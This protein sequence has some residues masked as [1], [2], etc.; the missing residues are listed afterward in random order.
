SLLF[1]LKNFTIQISLDNFTYNKIVNKKIFLLFYI[2]T[3]ALLLKYA[4]ISLV[5][6]EING[7]TV[8][9]DE[10]LDLIFGGSSFVKLFIDYIVNPIT[11]ISY[12]FL[13]I[14]IYS[15]NKQNWKFYVIF[16]VYLISYTIITGGRSTF[17]IIIMML[18]ISTVCLRSCYNKIK[19]PKTYYIIGVPTLIIILT[20]MALQTGYRESGKY[21]LN[22]DSLSESIYSMGESF[23]RYSVIPIKLFDVALDKNWDDK[24]GTF[25]CGKA[26]FAGMDYIVCRTVRRFTGTEP[27][28]GM[29]V[30]HD[31]QDQ[32]IRIIPSSNQG[33]NYC[34]TAVF[35]N[36]LD[37]GIVGVFFIPFI[38]GFIY[39]YYIL[40]FEKYRT[41]P[42]LIIVSFGYYLMLIALF[43]NYFIKTYIFIFCIFMA[44]W[45]RNSMYKS[46]R[47][48][49]LI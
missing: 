6:A 46:N 30:V 15:L 20:G 10:R 39:R 40:M 22:E 38:F 29:V 31:L 44:I 43:N 28:S 18:L 1:S 17:V 48:K 2:F 13:G 36:Y 9:Y 25:N 33:Y 19:I 26:T 49:R 14:S 41:L 4:L 16:P 3:S 8:E 7:G 47:H 24:Y 11:F 32:R 45:C 37:F 34:Y 5:I 27:W 12:V 21:E 42:L 23:L 35:Y